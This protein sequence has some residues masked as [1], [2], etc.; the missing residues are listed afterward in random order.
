M[1]VRRVS[2]F[3]PRRNSFYAGVLRQ[4]TL[5]FETC[6]V[7]VMGHLGLLPA[8]ELCD[9]C[10]LHR[11][12][13]VF[14]MNR[15][16]CEVQNLPAGV[17]HVVWVVDMQGRGMGYYEGSA[18]T[19][20][21]ILGS[22]RSYP[23]SSFC[24][25]MG[26]GSC[27]TDYPEAAHSPE[28]T[29]SFVGHIPRP[30]S[31]TELGRNVTGGRAPITLRD[32]VE[33]LTERLLSIREM[34]HEE[35]AKNRLGRTGKSHVLKLA[36]QICMEKAGVP[37][38]VDER[39]AYDIDGRMVRYANRRELGDLL[40]D[41]TAT[42]DIYGSENWMLWP[43][44]A[45]YYRGWLDTPVKMHGVYRRS[46]VNVHEGVGIHFRSM[47]ILSTG[48]L[49]FFR[50]TGYDRYHGGIGSIF[51]AGEH[52][53][54]FSVV[55]FRDKVD[56]YSRDRDRAQRIRRAAAAEIRAKHTWTHRTRQILDDLHHLD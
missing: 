38:L 51:E 31:S 50:A 3:F 11:P 20:F 26:P 55:D 56:L 19:Y 52:Y 10:R 2:L 25:W 15:P 53:V 16:G 14:E 46:V 45:A 12:D 29:V 49:L 33:P 4:M 17:R 40:V 28:T 39:L 21:L 44:Y 8:E 1:T 27:P 48:G 43:Q 47:D 13:V 6:G 32:L 42:T 35:R 36:S 7:E 54:P 18:I 37:L 41:G 23:H 34:R 22:E 5:G 9:W 30:W 24:R